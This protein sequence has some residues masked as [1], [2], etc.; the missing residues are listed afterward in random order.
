[1]ESEKALN[2]KFAYRS[3]RLPRRDLDA[4]KAAA[5]KL[6]ISQSEFMRQALRD[7]A[8][9]ILGRDGEID[10]AMGDAILK[11]WGA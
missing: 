6:E 5:A 4:W 3:F 2:E 7:K 11:R 9:R 8:N 10:T 1:M